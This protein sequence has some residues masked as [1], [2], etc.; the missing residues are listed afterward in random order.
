MNKLQM[1]FTDF[2][3]AGSEA[4]KRITEAKDK[5]MAYAALAQA[6]AESKL[7]DVQTEAVETKAE[8]TGKESLKAESSKGKTKSKAKEKEVKEEIVPEVEAETIPEA[9]AEAIPEVETS[10]EEVMEEEWSEKMQEVKAEQLGVLNQ[11]IE[12]WGEEYIVTECMTRFFE[13]AS[14]TAD[15]LWAYI[16]PTNIDGFVAYL[17]SIAE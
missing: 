12:A 11:Y 17:A 16:R 3:N 15:Q 9:E 10:T 7:M 6:I 1:A 2:I 14:I 8:V 4:A 13:D 5:A